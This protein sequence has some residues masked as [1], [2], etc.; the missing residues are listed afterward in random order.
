MVAALERVGLARPPPRRL[1]AALA[2]Y[3]RAAA[4]AT[5]DRRSAPRSP[6]RGPQRL[7]LRPGRA[8]PASCSSLA[9]EGAGDPLLLSDIARLRGHIEVNIGSATEAHRIFVEAAH[10]VHQVDPVRALE[11]ARRSGH[12]HLRRRQRL[13]V[14]DGRRVDVRGR[15]DTPRTRCLQQMLQR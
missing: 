13:K 8:G 15:G 7:G 2:A 9:R 12:A 10:E 1:R 4:L 11:I 14:A 3:E 5:T 6:S